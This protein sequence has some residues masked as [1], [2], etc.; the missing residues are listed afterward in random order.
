MYKVLVDVRA[1][2]DDTMCVEYS[3]IEHESYE[4]ALAER[5]EATKKCNS[6]NVLDIW[7][8]DMED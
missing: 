3:G 5:K 2:Y 7:I 1:G 4:D 8:E 6:F